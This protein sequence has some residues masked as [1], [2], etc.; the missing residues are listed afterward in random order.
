MAQVSPGAQDGPLVL[1]STTAPTRS[2]QVN[3][4]KMSKRFLNQLVG[5]DALQALINGVQTG[6]G[7]EGRQV[8]VTS[9][10]IEVAK[11]GV[12][13]DGTY[14]GQLSMATCYM[15]GEISYYI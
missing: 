3:Q 9:C 14:K 10:Y 13:V 5:A 6:D 1:V 4:I 15:P 11:G 2:T 8:G 7:Q 12:V